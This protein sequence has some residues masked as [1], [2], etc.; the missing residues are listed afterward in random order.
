MRH[1]FDE[2]PVATCS[3]ERGFLAYTGFRHD[4]N[5]RAQRVE[6]ARSI[7]PRS[8]DSTLP[9]SMDFVDSLILMTYFQKALV[10]L[11]HR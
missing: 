7:Q 10:Q 11:N 3:I 2:H 1:L 5:P 6:L 4:V 8:Q 9:E